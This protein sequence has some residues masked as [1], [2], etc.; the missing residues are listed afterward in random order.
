LCDFLVNGKMVVVD[1]NLCVGCQSCM[2][3]CTRRFGNAG[4]GKSAIH[5]GSAGGIERGFVVIIC[6]GCPDPPCMKV[7]PSNALRKRDGG[8]VILDVGKCIGCKN[9]LRECTIGAI[10]WDE[11]MNKPVICVHCGICENYCPYGVLKLEKKGDD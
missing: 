10:F 2:F 4:L 3:A 1:V 5:I 8:G 11:E 6:R 7:C 9:C